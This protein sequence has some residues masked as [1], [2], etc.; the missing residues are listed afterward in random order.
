MHPR[1]VFGPQ[2]LGEH[3][4]QRPMHRSDAL[5]GNCTLRTTMKYDLVIHNGRIVTA[6]SVSD[7][8]VWIGIVGEKIVTLGAG[9]VPLEDCRESID[10]GGAYVTPGG[11]DSHVHLE[12]LQIAPGE[13]TGDT[14]YSGTRSAIAGGT[15]T[16]IAF[17]NQQRHD[18]SLL[19]LVQE[20]HRRAAARTTFTD[21]AFHMI[22]TKPSLKILDEE[23]PVLF[24][25]EGITS[26]KVGA[27]STK[28]SS[29]WRVS[30]TFRST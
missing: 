23:L 12:Q 16:I 9:P 14:F 4:V 2:R 28:L 15:T 11:I 10:A 22:L 17:A 19:P 27:K 29:D 26:I 5:D 24:E 6:S 1:P 13:D 3:G 25:K 30:L 18:E 7:T 8:S 20:Y 21:Y